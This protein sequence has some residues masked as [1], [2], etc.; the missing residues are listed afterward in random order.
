MDKS[1]WGQAFA[2]IR[3]DACG[4]AVIEYGLLVALIAL[5]LLGTLMETGSSVQ[6]SLEKV[7]PALAN[8]PDLDRR[9]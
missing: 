9:D 8:N 5:A 3:G 6:T 7:P 2:A 1:K 4:A